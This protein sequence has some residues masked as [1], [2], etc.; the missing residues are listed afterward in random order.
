M[1]HRPIRMAVALVALACLTAA[2][3]GG[4]KIGEGL[5]AD[6]ELQGGEGAI[7]QRTTT[8]APAPVT[9]AAATATTV[10]PTATTVAAPSVI[11][12]IQDDNKGQYIEPLHNGARA[13]S[14]VR[15]VNE[16][17]TPHTITLK[18]GGTV[19]GPSP[20]IAPGG[21]TWDVRP[22]AKGTY[23][24]VDNERTYAVGATLTIS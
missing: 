7:G 22:T 24:I 9:T 10:K 2:C 8:T 19:V 21:G 15:F 20:T 13:G 11:F 14:L 5:E 17:D 16:D 4:N 6:G 23:D 3:G 1:Q 18:A 12:K